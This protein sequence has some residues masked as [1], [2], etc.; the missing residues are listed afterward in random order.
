MNHVCMKKVLGICLVTLA[1][2]A[3]SGDGSEGKE[4]QGKTAE[5]LYTMGLDLYNNKHYVRSAMAF[6]EVERQYPYSNIALKAQLASSYAYYVAKKYSEAIENYR[7]F[8]QL[9]PSH[10]SIPYAY[11]MLGVCYYE[12]IPSPD[13][14]QSVTRKAYDAF[15]EVVKRYPTSKY[16]RMAKLKMDLIWDHLASAEMKV[17]LFYLEKNS[18]LSAVNRFQNLI[19]NYQSTSYI[20][21]ALH[22]LVESYVGLGIKDQAIASAAVLGHNYPKSSWYKDSY[23]LLKKTGWVG[24]DLSRPNPGPGSDKKTPV[25][26]SGDKKEAGVAPEGFPTL[27]S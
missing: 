27:S 25:D 10:P 11:F 5:Q 6:A 21:E 13:R 9:H 2:M 15:E 1:L 19:D 3:C 23:E 12:Q 18:Y 7:V 16:A 22:R 26:L 14:D 24:K 4:Y 8:I 20:P 17:G